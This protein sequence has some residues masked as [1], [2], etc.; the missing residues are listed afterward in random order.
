MERSCEDCKH[1]SE[2]QKW[3]EVNDWTLRNSFV[4]ANDKLDDF[5]ALVFEHIKKGE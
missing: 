5:V 3:K 1:Y 2:N 4:F